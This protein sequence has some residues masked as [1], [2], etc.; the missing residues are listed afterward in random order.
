MLVHRGL[1]QFSETELAQLNTVDT[2]EE[3]VE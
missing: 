2:F 3:I 1:Y